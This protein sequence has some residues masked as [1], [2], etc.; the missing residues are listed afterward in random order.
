MMPI[1]ASASPAKNPGQYLPASRSI[2]F[3]KDPHK[4]IT[5]SSH[6]PWWE[7]LL[8]GLT[9]G[10]MNVVIDAVSLAIEDAV[11][12]AIGN[13]GISSNGMG[14]QLVTWPGQNA[15]TPDRRWP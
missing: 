9:A 6:I 12:G 1:S 10:I 5:H 8:G 7:K 4:S 3:A 2:A 15:I 14:A 13:T 11:T